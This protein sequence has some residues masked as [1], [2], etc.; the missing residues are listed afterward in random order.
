MSFSKKKPNH[1]EQKKK[2]K[3]DRQVLSYEELPL[4]EY[5]KQDKENSV[6]LDKKKIIAA[7]SVVLVLV[8]CVLMYFGRG[9]I[10]SCVG[11]TSGDAEFSVPIS[12]L[13]VEA[14][15]FRVFSQGICY[16]S[17]TGFT[18][19]S[20]DGEE[21]LTHHL[22]F[23]DPMLKVKGTAAIIYDLGATGYTICSDLKVMHSA[24]AQDSIYLGDISSDF[25]YALVTE[26]SGYNARLE[27]YSPDHKLI[28]A[29]NFSEYYVTSMALNSDATGAVVCGV[30]TDKGVST[31][32]VY[33]LDFTREEPVAKHII[34]DDL[35]FDCDYLSDSSICAIGSSG[36]YICRGR[37]F[38]TLSKKTY[39]Q[40]TLTSYDI[41]PDVGVLALSLSRSGDGRNCSI[42]YINSSGNTEKTIETDLS[43][44]SVSTF[45]DRVAVSDT[46]GVYIYRNSGDLLKSQ[47]IASDCKQI[48]MFSVDGLYLLGLDDITAFKL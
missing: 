45:K 20:K 4:E 14:G 47:D 8:L 19:L 27:A 11:V 35:I 39:N 13:D 6:K 46:A 7:V 41:N 21:L 48:R 43:L 1:F 37:S 24:D 3:D 10:A 32:A 23:G 12:G 28:Y 42:E 25:S 33:V 38:G 18:Y 22:G 31:S 5:E 40:M 36:T 17:D 9:S 2:K 16:A 44:V 29:Y 26:T 34:T 30:S 15:N